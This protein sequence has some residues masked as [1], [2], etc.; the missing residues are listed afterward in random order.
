VERGLR[1][2]LVDKQGRWNSRVTIEKSEIATSDI[3]LHRELHISDV[4]GLDTATQV[5]ELVSDI[6][7]KIL[8]FA[9]MKVEAI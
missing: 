1:F 7:R 4:S 8:Q 9:R 6:D 3:F 2:K 5:F